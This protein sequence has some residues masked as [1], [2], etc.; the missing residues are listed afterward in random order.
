[1]S[2]TQYGHLPIHTP[3]K[4]FLIGDIHN[5][6]DKLIN[7]LDQIEPLLTAEDHIVFT[8]D[9]FDRGAQATE[10]FN[11]LVNLVRRH[12]DQ[13]F[14]VRGN[15]DWMLQ[16]YLATGSLGWISYLIVTLDDWKKSWNL[17]SVFP[18]VLRPELIARGYLAITSR[19]VPYYETDKLIAT[20]AP[21][22]LGAYLS[23]GGNHYKEDYLDRANNPAFT[24]LLDRMGYDILWTF[25]DENVVIS[26]L[27]K[28]R[29]CG[30]QA[31]YSA[32][33]RIFRDR[34]FIDTGAGKGKYPITC[35]EWPSKKF[36]QGK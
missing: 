31:A 18:E 25:T 22:D 23:H 3:N 1:M 19:T 33:P 2:S 20:H 15:H 21:I 5:E 11:E 36:Y 26:G 32:T 30:H 9:L 4:V 13:V 35:L 14:F 34:A 8:G 24:Y 10:T 7:L 6:A 17:Q 12:P 16:N 29:V 28:F 27:D